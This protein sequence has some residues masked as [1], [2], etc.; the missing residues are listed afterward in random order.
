MMNKLLRPLYL[1]WYLPLLTGLTILC[2]T[3]SVAASF[4]S[5]R[6]A[7]YFTNIVWSHIVLGPAG[8]KL[9][10]TGLEN[11]PSG[12]G[13]FIIFANHNSLLDIPAL[14]LATRAPLTWV[15]KASL[16]R[17]PF[18]GWALAR[19][20]LLVDREGGAQAALRLVKEAGDRLARGEVLSIF[21]EG[22]RRHGPE[23][24]LPFKK[25]AFILARQTQAQAVPV[26]LK[27]TGALWPAGR[28]GPCPG[29][30]RVRLG[31]PLAPAPGEKLAAFTR[32]AQEALAGLLADE[33]W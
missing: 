33:S 11:L 6:L 23:R 9:A 5:T 29:L 1:A 28:L 13:G 10:V 2:G 15:A 12:P 14:G 8:L 16:G 22:T 17:I 7:R 19:V 3:V 31:P 24:L 32:R 25:G 27:N 4:F 30:I 21:P 18:F 26:A 20:H